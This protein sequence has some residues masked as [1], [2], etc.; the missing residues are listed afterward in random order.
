[1]WIAI[2]RLDAGAVLGFDLPVL[3]RV[4]RTSKQAGQVH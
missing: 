3:Q 1:V 2:T 4:K